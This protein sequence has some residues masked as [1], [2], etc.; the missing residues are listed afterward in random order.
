MSERQEIRI[1]I[2]LVSFGETEMYN[3]VISKK[4]VIDMEMVNNVSQ[5]E[6]IE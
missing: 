1:F 2:A 5:W 4:R 6:L 3:Y